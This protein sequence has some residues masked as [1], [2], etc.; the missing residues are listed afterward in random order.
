M[1]WK[2]SL[3]GLRKDLESGIWRG[4]ISDNKPIIDDIVFDT[5]LMKQGKLRKFLAGTR[6]LSRLFV[7][8][9][10]IRIFEYELRGEFGIYKI[11]ISEITDVVLSEGSP[12]KV[13]IKGDFGR[14][15]KFLTNLNAN[16]IVE[17]I[18]DARIRVSK[19]GQ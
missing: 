4:V 13:T 3:V 6:S 18:N 17:K 7:T 5:F 19:I 16:S 8:E 15:A 12:S 2:E 11:P 9:E 10:H 14:E 1:D